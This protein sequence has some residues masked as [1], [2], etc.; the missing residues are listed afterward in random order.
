MKENYHNIMLEQIQALKGTPTLLLQSCCGPCSSYV[1]EVLSKYFKVTVLYYNPNIFPAEEY[2]KRLE[3]QI[4]IINSMSFENEVCLLPCDY[5]PDEFSDCV[6]GFE[7]EPEGGL[8][9]RECFYLRMAKTAE[10]AKEKD[11]DF[12][13]TTLSVSPHKNAKLL[14]EIGKELQ[15]KY[16][17]NYLFA[18][19]KKKEGYKRSIEL[20]KE[21]DLYRQEYCGC[22]F[23]LQQS[24][25]RMKND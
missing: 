1:L 25:R 13:T 18:D 6:K 22:K 10:L 19:F 4:K 7:N 11:F 12:F 23:S 8:R 9:C 2:N 17:I 14:N 20:S 21:F 3:Q 24:E 16:G 5:R 15:E